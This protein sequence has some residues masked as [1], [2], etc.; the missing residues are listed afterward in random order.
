MG[1]NFISF[2]LQTSYVLSFCVANATCMVHPLAKQMDEA[3]TQQVNYTLG[4][5]YNEQKE[6][7]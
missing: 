6:C 1:Y 4:A 5:N 7:S 3:I 2:D